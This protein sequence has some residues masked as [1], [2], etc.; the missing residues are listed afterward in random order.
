VEPVIPWKE[1]RAADGKPYYYNA[2]TGVTQW[3]PPDGFAEMQQHQVAIEQKRKRRERKRRQ[4]E[5]EEE[6]SG[7]TKE[8]TNNLTANVT[9]QL[10]NELS[11]YSAHPPPGT[12]R[13]RLPP[14]PIFPY[15]RHDFGAGS[16]L[17][18]SPTANNSA[19]GLND[20]MGFLPRN[21]AWDFVRMSRT[22]DTC[23]K[24]GEPNALDHPFIIYRWIAKMNA[25]AWAPAGYAALTRHIPF[26]VVRPGGA[27]C[28]RANITWS[29]GGGADPRRV[30]YMPK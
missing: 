16:S 23:G 21:A 26:T 29:V 17:S 24:D 30:E 15:G 3:D 9:T 19:G 1:Y 10:E 25:D 13:I 5:E 6:N 8:N 22:Y 27:S 2:E 11:S 28:W 14:T 20:I 12:V 4:Q 7:G 18:L